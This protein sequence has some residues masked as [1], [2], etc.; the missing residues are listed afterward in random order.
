MKFI[1]L[2]R[3][4]LIKDEIVN[5]KHFNILKFTFNNRSDISHYKYG[6]YSNYPLCCI[7]FFYFRLYTFVQLLHLFDRKANFWIWYSKKTNFLP[8]SIHVIC[9]KCTLKYLFTKTQPKYKQTIYGEALI[10]ES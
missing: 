10:N 1:V 7:L 5:Y 9:P 4:F 6:R 3:N 2:N 8:N